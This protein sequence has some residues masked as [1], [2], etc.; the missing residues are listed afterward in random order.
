MT[1]A[2]VTAVPTAPRGSTWRKGLRWG[3]AL[4]A[5]AFVVWVVPFRDRCTEA[6][7]EPGL[8]TTLGRARAELLILALV[9]YLA[10]TGVWALRW[11]T[12]LEL[13]G[14]QLPWWKAWR[15]TL[16]AQA[17]GILLPGGLGGD[18]LRIA[19]V[20]DQQPGADLGNVIASIFVDRIIGLS[21]L[22]LLAALS[23][24][25][26]SPADLG[27]LLWFVAAIP[28][29]AVFLFVV[30]RAVGSPLPASLDLPILRR[31]LTPALRYATDP[32][33]PRLLFRALLL[34]LVTSAC[35][36]G[37]IRLA[38]LALHSEPTS[39]AGVYVGTTLGM[40][41]AA[42][43]A[44]PGA[45]GTA[46]TAYVFFL[47]RAGVAASAA[48]AACMLYRCYWYI[49]GILGAVLALGSRRS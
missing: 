23:A 42:L 22:A 16:E 37:V 45:W 32:R 47:G 4:I 7:C 28:V 21:T 29:G 1:E 26:T 12:L 33:G 17:G 19:Y 18:A 2:L 11:N 14:V 41:V 24:T 49:S 38:L 10:S 9:V 31:V 30:L 8:L 27:V 36:L 6:G 34:S 25:V 15:L 5:F 13:A 20:R 40:M 44:T 35:Q 3:I 48:A 39:E 46:D 43:P